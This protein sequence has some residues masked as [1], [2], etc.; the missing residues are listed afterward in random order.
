MTDISEEY[1]CK[2]IC[3]MIKADDSWVFFDR[4]G[5]YLKRNAGRILQ[6]E[7]PIITNGQYMCVV[8]LVDLNEVSKK[9]RVHVMPREQ[10]RD[11]HMNRVYMDDIYAD[12]DTD[13]VYFE[14]CINKF[15]T[16]E[17]IS[18]VNVH[19]ISTYPNGTRFCSI[20]YTMVGDLK[21]W[22]CYEFE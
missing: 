1:E 8:R 7:Q 21:D 6:I 2:Y 11:K 3:T 20:S 9:S 22:Y 14:R 10:S 4:L 17:D 13:E 15:A 12:P 19:P 18:V 16:R 5:D